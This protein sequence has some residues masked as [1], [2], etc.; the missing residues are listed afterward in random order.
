MAGKRNDGEVRI[1]RKE[2]QRTLGAVAAGWALPGLGHVLLGRLGRGL[3]FGAIVWSCFALGL[4][5]DGRLALRDPKQPFLTSL[6]VVANL[7][8]GPVD[9]VARLAVYGSVVYRMPHPA[10]QD[11][12]EI[13]EIFRDRAKSGVSIYGTAYLWTAGL[14]NLLLLFDIWDIGRKKGF[15][16]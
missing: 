2:L 11:A 15:E 4:T 5:H 3:I 14:M 7:G 12:R 10:K 16:A 9:M 1:E 8:V 13:A 6:Q